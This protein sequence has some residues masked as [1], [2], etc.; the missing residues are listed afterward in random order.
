ME[1]DRWPVVARWDGIEPWHQLDISTAEFV[2][3]VIADPE[4]KPFTVAAPPRR[5]FYLPHWGP[6]PMS[7]D[8][9]D[10]LTSPAGRKPRRETPTYLNHVCLYSSRQT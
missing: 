9:W 5:P 3:R 6:F 2:Y 7:A 1:T 8:D 4:F 10:A